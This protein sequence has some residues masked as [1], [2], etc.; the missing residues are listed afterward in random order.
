MWRAAP[1]QEPVSVVACG[2]WEGG[3]CV[4]VTGT[5]ST[6]D[7]AEESG[8]RGMWWFGPDSGGTVMVP[9]DVVRDVNV[10]V[11]TARVMVEG[12]VLAAGMA[13]VVGDA[14]VVVVSVV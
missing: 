6:T 12:V 10:V 3:R 2:G 7:T 13:A 8:R 14:L 5:S 11:V 1:A 4:A 9:V